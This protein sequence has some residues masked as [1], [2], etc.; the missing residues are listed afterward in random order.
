MPRRKKEP[1]KT[2]PEITESAENIYIVQSGRI[3]NTEG[4]LYPGDEIALSE[5]EAK[6]MGTQ[7]KLKGVK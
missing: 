4:F 1:E 2:E 6:S 3:K 5:K 7:V